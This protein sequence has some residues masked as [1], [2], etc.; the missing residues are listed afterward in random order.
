[1]VSALLRATLGEI[2]LKH[3]VEIWTTSGDLVLA[4]KA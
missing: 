3:L 2:C 4:P 1:M